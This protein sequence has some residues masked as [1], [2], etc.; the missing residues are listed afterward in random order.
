MRL[1]DKSI[2]TQPEK[3]CLIYFSI[4]DYNNLM[5]KVKE[6]GLDFINN[7][8]DR[9]KAMLEEE[10]F[11]AQITKDT[12][13]IGLLTYER[14]DEIQQFLTE[15]AEENRKPIMLHETEVF[16]TIKSGVS[17]YPE[18]G[19]T[20]DELL[21]NAY[22]AMKK[23]I[24]EKD[25][26]YTYYKSFLKEKLEKEIEMELC[27]RKAIAQSELKVYYQPQVEIEPQKVAGAEALLRW[28]SEQLGPISP[29]E[30]IPVAEKTGQILEIGY[31][32]IEQIFKDYVSIREII[33]KDF[34]I[35]INI[36]PLQFKDK[37]LMPKFKELASKYRIDFNH[38]EVEITESTFIDDIG[39]VNEKLR[40]IRSLGMTVAIDDFGTGFSSL[41]Y[42]KKLHID[43][44]KIDRSFIKDYPKEDGG[45]IAK[46]ITNMSKDLKL[47]V[48]TEGAETKE[49]I[50]YL[51]TIGCNLIQGYYYSRPLTKEKF[52]KYIVD[53]NK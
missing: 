51:Q 48:I 30:F 39:I 46:V 16:V 2:R 20:S 9:M 32:L 14:N 50:D 22:I 34:R 5:L 33:D 49:Q 26:A 4:L 12:F 7:L 42:L 10:D 3:F 13:V 27:L 52:E 25:K 47:K 41:S 31:W 15:M 6:E 45:E 24:D 18:D 11:I 43:K 23:V 36:S 28:N 38:F 8:I 44:L 1:I 40:E 17:I 37:Q 53:N 29:V 19:N 35:S 21:T